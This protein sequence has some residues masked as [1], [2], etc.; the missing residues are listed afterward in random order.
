[1]KYGY[2]YVQR[3][4]PFW[5]GDGDDVSIS[6]EGKAGVMPPIARRVPGPVNDAVSR[7]PL[8]GDRSQP[9][10]IQWRYADSKGTAPGYITVNLSQYGGSC[11]DKG[12]G[13]PS[14]GMYAACSAP[15]AKHAMHI[16]PAV[17]QLFTAGHASLTMSS[18][19][20][21]PIITQSGMNLHLDV[22][23]RVDTGEDPNGNGPGSTTSDCGNLVL[24]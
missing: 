23:A 17:L 19:A 16:P 24:H 11:G 15:A 21:Q 22:T 8:S 2:P 14:F 6:I 10:V 1:M 3:P 13:P 5:N 12:G 20:D 4:G 18:T 9:F 7:P